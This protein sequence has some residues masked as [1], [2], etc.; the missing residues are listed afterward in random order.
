MDTTRLLIVFRDPCVGDAIK[1]LLEDRLHCDGSD[2][3]VDWATNEAEAKRRLKNQKYHLLITHLHIL[4]DKNSS[5]QAEEQ[6][7]LILLQALKKEDILIPSILVSI[8]HDPAVDCAADDL[9]RC[10]VII[11]GEK[12]EDH[13]IR[14]CN[15]KLAEMKGKEERAWIKDKEERKTATVDLFLD[16]DNKSWQFFLKGKGSDLQYSAD[17]YLEINS[18]IMEDLVKRTQNIKFFP[19]PNWE[20]ELREIGL[21]LE[22]EFFHNN[23]KFIKH[24]YTLKAKVGDDKDIKFRFHVEKTAHPIILEALFQEDENAYWML[25]SPIYRALRVCG[26]VYPLFE[27]LETRKKEIN[28]LIIESDV[29][30]DG[31]ARAIN[32]SL[33]K[34]ENVSKESAWLEQYLK[35]HK[36]Q[37]KI[38]KIKRINEIPKGV[39]FRKH[40]Q[41]TLENDVWHLVHYAGHSHYD[42]KKGEGHVFFPGEDF[43]D[44]VDIKEFSKWLR[45]A[46]TGFVYL[47]SCHSSEEAFAF[48]LAQ[49]R[50][51]A[52]I[53][54]RWDIDDEMATDH[55][56]KFY[57]HLFKETRSLE[58]AFLE[59]RKEMHDHYQDN[60][61]WAAPVLVLQISD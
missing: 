56:K 9:Y 19:Y 58:Y 50:I 23:H 16:L 11:E 6:R 37:F 12:F 25:K 33:K 24:F 38:G 61:I 52:I 55:T 14:S 28:C 34:L 49:N 48:E 15:K 32:K 27:D 13:L 22:K 60:R 35:D 30:E 29:P 51:P 59:T 40:L 18:K 39:T 45:D 2:L 4:A 53:G 1:G 41:N 5:P 54:F 8:T 31:Y 44:A 10:R 42:G 26:E 21:A 7:G 17:G 3:I 20:E 47:S 57:E 46:K 43:V 36:G